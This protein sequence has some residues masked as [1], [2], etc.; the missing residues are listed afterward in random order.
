MDRAGFHDVAIRTVSKLIRSAARFVRFEQEFV[1]ALHQLLSRLLDMELQAAWQQ[2]EEQFRAVERADRFV[3][4]CE[5]L[6]GVGT[7]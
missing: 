2:S 7:K 3:G 4:P 1:G 5:L 6:V